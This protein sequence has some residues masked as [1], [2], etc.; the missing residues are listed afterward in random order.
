MVGGWFID[1]LVGLVGVSELVGWFCW[2]VG[3][4]IDWWV[5][6]SL[7]D[8]LVGLVGVSELAGW[9]CWWVG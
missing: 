2:W 8:W 7:I 3:W 6:G 5:G 1:C 4:S 9:F